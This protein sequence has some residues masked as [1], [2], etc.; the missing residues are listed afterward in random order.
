MRTATL[1]FLFTDIEGHSELWD[2]HP[3]AMSVALSEHD[4]LITSAVAGAAGRVVKNAGD[5]AMAVFA[6]A[7][8]AVD[9]AIAIQRALAARAW[10]EV[11]SLRVRM[12][13]NSGAAEA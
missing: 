2:R 1:T 12:G 11:G 8:Q 4:E 13:L 3:D 5:G 9:A 7:S 6:E 10:P